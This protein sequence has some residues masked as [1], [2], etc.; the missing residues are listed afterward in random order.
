MVPASDDSGLSLGVA[1]GEGVSFGAQERVAV[2][3]ILSYAEDGVRVTAPGAHVHIHS[4]Y[5][6]YVRE[7]QVHVHGVP[8]EVLHLETEALALLA[9]GH[10][11]GVVVVGVNGESQLA[12]Q[13]QS[14]SGGGNGTEGKYRIALIAG[15]EDEP[16][17]GQ[18]QGLCLGN[19]RALPGAVDLSAVVPCGG[20]QRRHVQGGVSGNADGYLGEELGEVTY[21]LLAAV[22]LDAE[23][24]GDLSHHSVQVDRI[25]GLASGLG[26][27]FLLAQCS[28]HEVGVGSGGTVRQ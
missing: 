16:A 14:L 22:L 18:L 12:V 13:F 3:V 19:G 26:V 15:G 21:K 25:Y 11:Q 17:V 23:V 4:R 10:G 8:H 7:V 6:D 28:G 27:H 2:Q 20:V 5:Y 9:E 24:D 1:R